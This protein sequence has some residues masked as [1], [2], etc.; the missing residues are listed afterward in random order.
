M[1]SH[2]LSSLAERPI[3]PSILESVQLLLV[4]RKPLVTGQFS[5]ALFFICHHQPANVVWL[6]Y[7]SSRLRNHMTFHWSLSFG[8][9]CMT[10]VPSSRLQNHMRFHRSPSI[11]K[12]W[13]T[14]VSFVKTTDHNMR[15][16][17]KSYKDL[18]VSH[19]GSTLPEQIETWGPKFC[20]RP[21]CAE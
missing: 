14:P 6:Q 4:L 11:S 18:I 19:L 9:P 3:L 2:S 15:F 1:R 7:P 21:D 10:P 12:P 17:D 13:M 5:F 20:I 16:A 8:K